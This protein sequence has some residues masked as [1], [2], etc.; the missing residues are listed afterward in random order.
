MFLKSFRWNVL[1]HRSLYGSPLVFVCSNLWGGSRF[2][3]ERAQG[4]EQVRGL[5]EAGGQPPLQW[6]QRRWQVL[7]L[8]HRGEQL[9]ENLQDEA[10]NHYS[11]HV[12]ILPKIKSWQ[13]L[14]ALMRHVTCLHLR[15]SV[16]SQNQKL[17]TD[18]TVAT[19]CI[20]L[21]FWAFCTKMYPKMQVEWYDNMY[22]KTD[23][24]Q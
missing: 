5:D 4:P 8:E 10:F 13:F 17:T 23:I 14:R 9:A 11:Q 6:V 18:V 15:V 12:N 3:C 21:N 2:L 24:C 7:I 20:V 1:S 16:S 22:C 19:F